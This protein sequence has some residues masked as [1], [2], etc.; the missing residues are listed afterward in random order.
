MYRDIPLGRIV[1][2]YNSNM[3]KKLAMVFG[4]VFLLVG[5]LGFIPN[6][7]VGEMNAIF[8]ADMV[9]NLIHIIT[10]LVLVYL[11]SKSNATAATTLKVVGVVY[12]VVALVGFIMADTVAGI[13]PVN[14]ADNWLHTVLGIVILWSGFGGKR[15]SNPMTMDM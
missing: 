15:N 4:I 10:G 3:T 14:V 13:I 11:G 7:I 8:H 9:H 6:P 1:I 5:V 2:I 12:L